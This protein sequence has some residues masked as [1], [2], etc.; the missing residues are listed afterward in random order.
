M[1][2]SLL[3]LPKINGWSELPENLKTKTMLSKMGLKPGGEPK[4]RIFLYV[5]SIWTPLYHLNEAVPKRKSSPEQLEALA[6]GREKQRLK[7]TC[8]ECG[9]EYKEKELVEQT[10]AFCRERRYRDIMI[11]KGR[12]IFQEWDRI[13][14]W[15]ILDVE[16]TGLDEE[17][18]IIE[19]GVI[20][21]QENILFE[22]LI[23]PTIP[24]PEEA[25]YIHGITNE[26]VA[27]APN[28]SEVWPKLQSVLAGR[29]ILISNEEFDKR[30]VM[31]TCGKWG[32][33]EPALQT[34]C[35]M[36]TYRLYEGVD[37]WTSLDDIRFYERLEKSQGRSR[38]SIGDCLT[39]LELIRK[40]GNDV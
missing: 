34:A 24:I 31:Q 20:D 16:T 4:A 19:I 40:I 22:S 38:R 11:E 27:E 7:R 5:N 37:R 17:A 6:K 33:Q 32:I 15:L 13:N 21:S 18:E 10:C 3:E 26:A 36:E 12:S 8:S 9:E 35:V 23:K 30:M 28:W 29:L 25:T 39:V 2:I 1:S 14:D